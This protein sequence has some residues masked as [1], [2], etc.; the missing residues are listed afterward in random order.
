MR[1]RRHWIG[2]EGGSMPA[3]DHVERSI[4]KRILGGVAELEVD[5][6]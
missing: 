2:K 3:D 6:D 1:K 4:G 5:V